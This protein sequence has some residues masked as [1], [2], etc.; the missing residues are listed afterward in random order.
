MAT[1]LREVVADEVKSQVENEM[2]PIRDMAEEAFDRLSRA[3]TLIA[4]GGI[5][6]VEY[7]A[8][9]HVK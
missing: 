1:A 2:A 5:L 6:T 3:A 4:Q 7:N 9:E 8:K